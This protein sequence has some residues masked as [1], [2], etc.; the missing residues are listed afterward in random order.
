MM[1]E[2]K[3]HSWVDKRVWVGTGSRQK[4]RIQRCDLRRRSQQEKQR[5]HQFDRQEWPWRPLWRRTMRNILKKRSLRCP[6]VKVLLLGFLV[7]IIPATRKWN[8]QACTI[9]ASLLSSVPWCPNL[10]SSV[11]QE[12]ALV[13]HHGLVQKN[14]CKLQEVCIGVNHPGTKILWL[15]LCCI[16]DN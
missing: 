6:F 13:V 8:S 5:R 16:N 11:A 3:E 7:T 15:K 1:S 14:V 9:D 12:G 10:S 2:K 4:E